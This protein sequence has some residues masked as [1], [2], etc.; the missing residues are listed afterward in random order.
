[1]KY[2]IIIN[3]ADESSSSPFVLWDRECKNVIGKPAAE[4]KVQTTTEESEVPNEIRDALLQKKYMFKIKVPLGE[5]WRYNKAYSV[6]TLATDPNVVATYSAK[7]SDSHQSNSV[8]MLESSNEV[9]DTIGEQTPVAA[10]SRLGDES[11]WIDDGVTKRSLMD[12]FS[13][14]KPAKKAKIE[15]KQEK[16]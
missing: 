14:T 8:S 12:E 15:I 13:S 7:C 2:K 9:M 11:E 6:S 1:M 3:V 4:V 5:G 16:D 10:Q